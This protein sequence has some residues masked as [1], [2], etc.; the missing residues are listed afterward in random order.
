MPPAP[1]KPVPDTLADSA[2]P[3]WQ[4]GDVFRAVL[5]GGLAVFYAVLMFPLT[6]AGVALWLL[7]KVLDRPAPDSST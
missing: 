1:P 5:F 2:H 7:A 4:S 6:V 3:T